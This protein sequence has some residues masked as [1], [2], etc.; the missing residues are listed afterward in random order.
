MKT[1]KSFLAMVKASLKMFMRNKGTIVFSLLLPM[2]M[3]SVFGFLSSNSGPAIRLA[4]TNHSTTEMA[5]EFEK[6]LVDRFGKLPKQAVDL[7]NSV[8]IK[9]IA[10]SIGLERVLMKRKR[11]VGYFIA[12]QQSGFYQSEVFTKVL[13]YVQT[14]HQIVTMKER[15]TRN[16]L[17]LLLTF[18]G[19]TS[20]DKALEVLKPFS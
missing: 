20:V 17:R 19:V 6:E 4:M 11:M 1:V 3:L 7:M 12:D 13:N 8:R 5:A 9:W 14:H 15:E 2:V 10:N 18:E 16:G